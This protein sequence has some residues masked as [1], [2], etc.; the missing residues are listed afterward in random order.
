MDLSALDEEDDAQ[1]VRA[2]RVDF[3]E[4]DT[5]H[6][7]AREALDAA[8]GFKEI[9]QAANT[10]CRIRG[11]RSATRRCCGPPMRAALGGTAGTDSLRPPL[12]CP[13]TQV[14][15]KRLVGVFSR[16]HR[17]PKVPLTCT[18]LG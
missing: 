16:N 18:F 6:I 2:R 17:E 12:L 13:R 5:E 15:R 11:C 8:T 1:A 3:R 7:A 9:Q 14:S 4:P 10:C